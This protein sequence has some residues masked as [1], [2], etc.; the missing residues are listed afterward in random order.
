[1]IAILYIYVCV[2]RWKSTQVTCIHII[3]FYD[4][5]VR[6]YNGKWYW[7]SFDLNQLK[8]IILDLEIKKLQDLA[9]ISWKDDNDAD[10]FVEGH[11]YGTSASIEWGKH[12]GLYQHPSETSDMAFASNEIEN[13]CFIWYTYVYSYY[14]VSFSKTIN[15]YITYRMFD[16]GPLFKSRPGT[17]L[18]PEPILEVTMQPSWMTP[19]L[20]I[21][22]GFPSFRSGSQNS[23]FLKHSTLLP[24]VLTREWILFH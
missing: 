11:I 5:E 4:S 14:C 23:T 21:N 6:K 12:L 20:P 22:P 8:N 1:M 9:I 3:P 2:Y 24:R 7:N 15:L 17:N 18:E 13:L 10:F 19:K 16:I